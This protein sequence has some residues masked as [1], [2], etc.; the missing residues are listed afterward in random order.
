[1][2]KGNFTGAAA[3]A[4]MAGKPKREKVVRAESV[5]RRVGNAAI[6]LLLFAFTIMIT[7]TV[8]QVFSLPPWT[9]WVLP[10]LGLTAFLRALRD[11]GFT[12]RTI[13]LLRAG[14]PLRPA[15]EISANWPI[16]CEDAG[17]FAVRHRGKQQIHIYPVLKSLET[18]RAGV[19]GLVK[20]PGAGLTIE[21]IEKKAPAL[22]GAFGFPVEIE[23]DPARPSQASIAF[24]LRDPLEGMREADV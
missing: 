2:S 12:P 7:G 23:L 16:H 15:W 24:K 22:G 9:V 8:V 20:T 4:Y 1:M 6:W 14:V 13:H 11:L 18:T 17:L 5:G 10:A 21:E 3:G 19:E